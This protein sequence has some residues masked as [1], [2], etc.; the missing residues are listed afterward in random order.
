MSEN[1]EYVLD[2]SGEELDQ[3]IDYFLNSK[4]DE[5][6]QEIF[7]A[8]FVVDL[9]NFTII[10]AST[11]YQEIERQLEA[12]KYVVGRGRYALVSSPINI[13]FFPLSA[14][15]PDQNLM[16]F[17][18]F[19]QSSINNTVVVLSITLEVRSSNTASVRARIVSTTDIN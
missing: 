8:D 19:I 17:S 2:H 16:L 3:A 13:G 18:G 5:D 10:D 15:V 6:V 7:Y 4:S 14:Y 1:N 9:A 11:T 12:G